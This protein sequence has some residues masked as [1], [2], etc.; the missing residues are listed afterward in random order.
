[1]KEYEMCRTCTMH[2]S[3]EDCIK[4]I[5]GEFRREEAVRKTKT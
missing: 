3:E 5:G 4:V 2:G 1:V